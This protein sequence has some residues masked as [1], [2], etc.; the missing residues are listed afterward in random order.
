MHTL[1]T[2][3]TRSNALPLGLDAPRAEI[4]Q[5]TG[6]SPALAGVVL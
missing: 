3:A 1:V 4:E 5:R 6:F 2:H